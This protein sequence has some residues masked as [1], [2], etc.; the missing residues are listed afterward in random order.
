MADLNKYKHHVWEHL[1][2]YNN[3][4]D[5]IK[6]YDLMKSMG[7]KTKMEGYAV[8]IEVEKWY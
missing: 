6:R 1:Y 5:A 4:K 3:E 8:Y 2:T 7:W